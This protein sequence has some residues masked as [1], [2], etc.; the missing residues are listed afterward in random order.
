M[1]IK[2]LL[3]FVPTSGKLDTRELLTQHRKNNRVLS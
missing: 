3:Q 2:T 1:S